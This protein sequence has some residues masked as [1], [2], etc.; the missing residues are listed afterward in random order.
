MPSNREIIHGWCCSGRETPNAAESAAMLAV[1]ANCPVSC[2]MSVADIMPVCC[3]CR[4]PTMHDGPVCYACSQTYSTIAGP[5][6]THTVPEL[7][8]LPVSGPEPING[9]ETFTLSPLQ[10]DTMTESA[11]VE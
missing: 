6:L 10:V 3:V 1:M 9:T 11:D 5:R 7:S 8:A 4:K 2:S